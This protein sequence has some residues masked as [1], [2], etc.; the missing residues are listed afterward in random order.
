MNQ[1][2]KNLSSF[3][4]QS[5]KNYDPPLE[6]MKELLL[7]YLTPEDIKDKNI[8]DAGCGIGLSCLIFSGWGAKHII[9]VD[10]SSESIQKA[11]LLKKK[12]NANN[13]EYLVSDLDKIDLLDKNFD[14]VFSRGVSFYSL[15]LQH[16]LDKLTKVTKPNGFLIIDFVRDSKIIY[17]T[18]RIGRILKIIPQNHQKKISKILSFISYPIIKIFLGKKA[19]LN[20]GKTVEQMFY[21]HFFSPVTMKT[22]NIDEIKKILGPN[23][24]VIDLNVPNIGLHSPKTSFYLKITKKLNENITN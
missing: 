15:D 16:Y 1:N 18:E 21:E 9:G 7:S 24:N 22:T 10:I 13:I 20:N 5:G 8:L 14:F 2:N 17:L 19:K 4:D 11:E 3:F 12:Y 6:E 23:Y